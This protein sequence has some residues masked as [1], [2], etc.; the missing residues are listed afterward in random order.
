MRHSIPL[1]T[2]IVILT[3]IISIAAKA[4]EVSAR[5]FIQNRLKTDLTKHSEAKTCFIDLDPGTVRYTDS[6]K[7]SCADQYGNIVV[8]INNLDIANTL[9]HGSYDYLDVG[10]VGGSKVIP[11][12]VQVLT[13]NGFDTQLGQR[14]Q[15]LA[16]KK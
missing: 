2:V 12:V 9:V 4:D 7:I 6:L 10:Y 3:S 11:V 14:Y 8:D 16:T 13:A 1:A 15:L 5:S